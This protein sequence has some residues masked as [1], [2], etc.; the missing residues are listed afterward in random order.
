MS[1]AS[2]TSS[3]LGGTLLGDGDQPGVEGCREWP[4]GSRVHALRYQHQRILGG[5]R[6]PAHGPPPRRGA[7]R[8][9]Q[10]G[11]LAGDCRAELLRHRVGPRPV[12]PRAQGCPGRRW[13]AAGC[14]GRSVEEP[15]RA[16]I[17]QVP[18]TVLCDGGQIAARQG[19]EADVLK[20]GVH[21]AEDVGVVLAR[22]QEPDHGQ[23]GQAGRERQLTDEVS[24][25]PARM[26]FHQAW[27]QIEASSVAGPYAILVATARAE[28]PAHR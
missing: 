16:F 6:A 5:Q 2:R 23:S 27:L 18:K 15:T 19:C 4:A 11:R 20:A 24:S 13:R 26:A 10:V 1:T 12:W 28:A 25:L 9:G 17:G 8:V 21:G 7:R 14:A 3:W 22:G